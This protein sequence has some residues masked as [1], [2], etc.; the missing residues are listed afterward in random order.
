MKPFICTLLLIL[1]AAA[2]GAAELASVPTTTSGPDPGFQRFL[3][4]GSTLGGRPGHRNRLPWPHEPG[5]Q[6]Q[7]DQL[8]CAC[9]L[10]V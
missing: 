10:P 3:T 7:S 4:G 9:E 6:L 1:L 5:H 2:G 8:L